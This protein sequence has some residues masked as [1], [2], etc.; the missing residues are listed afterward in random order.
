MNAR[1]DAVWV[2]DTIQQQRAEIERLR[3][4][5]QDYL[6]GN[7]PHPRSYRG[8]DMKCPHERYYYEECESCNDEYFAKLLAGH[9]QTTAQC[10]AAHMGGSHCVKRCMMPKDCCG[11][12]L[13]P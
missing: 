11:T 1:E 2:A 12:P 8:G 9:Q 5:I 13:A 6:D 4:G 3:K 10:V 7:Y